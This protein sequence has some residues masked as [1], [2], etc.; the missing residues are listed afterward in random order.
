MK[1]FTIDAR[2]LPCPRPLLRTKEAL[3]K[4]S[5]D[6]L[7]VLVNN[8]AARENVSRFLN[9]TGMSDVDVQEVGEMLWSITASRS[10]KTGSFQQEQNDPSPDPRMPADK[11]PEGKR[12]L[13]TSHTIGRGDDTLGA[14]L[15]KG[16]LYTLTQLDTP[17]D[18]LI[19]MN[20]GVTLTTQ[21]PE[22]VQNLKDLEQKGC[23]IVSCGT[24]LDFLKLSDH[25]AVGDISNM[26]EIAS[27]LM[28]QNKTVT[29]G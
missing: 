6:V 29:I 23:R 24:C 7:E 16:F 14:L 5:L 26:Y 22:S 11:N 4:E 25:L 9:K 17:P 15:M 10:L 27:L 21:D 1:K 18:T 28:D 13:V 12:I 3:E 8:P 19:F 2:D 20:S